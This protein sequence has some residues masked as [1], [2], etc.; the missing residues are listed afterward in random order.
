M[1]RAKCTMCAH[2]IRAA[3][4][5]AG[6]GDRFRVQRARAGI[7]RPLNGVAVRSRPLRVVVA[8][9][10]DSLAGGTQEVAVVR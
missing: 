3:R 5:G 9:P 6:S 1:T 8:G 2:S 7:H 4:K 10:L